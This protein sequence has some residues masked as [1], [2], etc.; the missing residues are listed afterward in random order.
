MKPILTSALQDLDQAGL[1]LRRLT[2]ALQSAP[3]AFQPS[4]QGVGPGRTLHPVQD[5]LKA[6]AAASTKLQGLARQPA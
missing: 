5:A 1:I 3:E 6:I 2:N 4:D